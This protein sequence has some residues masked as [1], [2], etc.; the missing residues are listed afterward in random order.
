MLVDTG[1]VPVGEEPPPPGLRVGSLVGV[2]VGTVCRSS[3][4]EGSAHTSGPSEASARM[5]NSNNTMAR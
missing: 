1:A 2:R 5:A 3:L 4:C